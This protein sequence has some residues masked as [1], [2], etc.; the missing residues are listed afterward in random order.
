MMRF[1]ILHL[2]LIMFL[3]AYGGNRTPGQIVSSEN[4]LENK[5]IFNANN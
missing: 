1:I 3:F 5:T 2:F 4:L